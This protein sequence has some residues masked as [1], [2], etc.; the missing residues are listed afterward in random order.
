[1]K[2]IFVLHVKIIPSR[3][4]QTI[5]SAGIPREWVIFSIKFHYPS[6]RDYFD[7]I[8]HAQIIELKNIRVT[9]IENKI[10]G[11]I[12]YSVNIKMD[13]FAQSVKRSAKRTFTRTF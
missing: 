8:V 13:Q 1:M 3:F 9:V 12:K 2:F 6:K 4:G 11:N 5:S 7:G 10:Q